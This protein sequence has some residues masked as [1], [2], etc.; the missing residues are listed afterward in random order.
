MPAAGTKHDSGQQTVE[1][2]LPAGRPQASWPL[3]VVAW[4]AALAALYYA[5]DLAIPLVFA[6]LLALLLRPLFR[7]LQRLRVP[8][9]A[10]SLLLV[11]GVAAI[12]VTGMVTVAQQGQT[13]LAKAPDM[14][15]NV[16][17]MLPQEQGPLSH[18]TQTTEAVRDL[19]EPETT[20]EEAPVPVVMRSS[21][22][23]ITVL[24]T[25]GHFLAALLIVFVVTFFVLAYSDTLLK[26]AVESR[27]SFAD[28]KAVVTSL[29]NVENGIS[30]YLAT[31]TVINIGLGIVTALVVW[32]LRIPNPI[33]WGLMAM[34]LNYVPHVGAL[35]CEVILFFVGAV[36]HESLWHGAGAAASF[37]V[38]TTVES[39]FI[40]PIALSKSLQLSPLAVILSVLFWGWLWGIAGGLMAAPLLTVVKIVCDQ[41]AS[42]KPM[43]LLLSGEVS[44]AAAARPEPTDK[45]LPLP[46]APRAGAA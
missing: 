43:S 35:A 38:L 33:L 25:S 16:Q 18:L 2:A 17:A 26:Q 4:I 46:Q 7:R 39:Y 36:A 15:K 31:V 37:F 1:S 6:V 45:T 29:N 23:T 5:R 44:D 32:M 11:L 24:G 9:V 8:D 28:K 27:N 12:F 3:V 34:V 13:W 21:E 41:F 20:A 22:A 40:T 14:I 30:T 42:L 10:A 19:A